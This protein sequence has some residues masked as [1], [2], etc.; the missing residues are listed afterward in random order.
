MK[1]PLYIMLVTMIIVIAFSFC[2]NKSGIGKDQERY[3]D[4]EYADVKDDAPQTEAVKA[5]D[6]KDLSDIRKFNYTWT[7]SDEIPPIVIIIDDFGYV[8]GEL[9]DD[10]ANLPK[11]V[12][13]AVLPDLA[14]SELAAQKAA[15]S[16][17]ETIIHIPMQAK[18]SNVSPGE[19]Y[20]KEGLSKNEVHD[21]LAGFHRQMP[22]AIGA[23]NHM[24][25]TSTSDPVLM[26]YVLSYLDKYDLGFVDS[27]TAPTSVA[28]SLAQSKGIKSVKRDIFLDVPDNS[29]ATIISK[30]EGLG[31][32]KGR[33]EP[34]IIISH[35]HNRDKLNALQS[36]ISQV[37][38]MGVELIDLKTA[39]RM[40]PL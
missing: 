3:G 19:R 29:D 16:G 2:K 21:M 11:E 8:K 31:K 17:R 33:R 12:V 6:K 25:S 35:C 40:Y 4:S 23:N 32:Y 1:K 18:T 10:F 5:E 24:G 9:L 27:F 28:F 39:M 22:M 37:K 20:I 30:I 38:A 13:F 14:Y 34:V 7:N 26:E 15:G 36:F